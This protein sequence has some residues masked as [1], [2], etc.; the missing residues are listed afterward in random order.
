MNQSVSGN[1][2]HLL[3]SS[4]SKF[5]EISS[6]DKNLKMEIYIIVGKVLVQKL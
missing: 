3:N 6:I 2:W 5:G 4:E 1:F